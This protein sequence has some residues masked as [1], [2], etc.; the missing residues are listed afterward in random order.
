MASLHVAAWVVASAVVL[1]VYASPIAGVADVLAG[2][3][4]QVADATAAGERAQRSFTFP[5]TRRIMRFPFGRGNTTM[6][7]LE[8]GRRVQDEVPVY[9]DYRALAYYYAD[10]YVG[11]PSQRFTVITDTGA[12]R[13]CR[14]HVDVLLCTAT[15]C[16]CRVVC[17]A[18]RIQV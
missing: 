18:A 7:N 9:G 5:L 15:V 16:G 10:V 2:S 6:P 4:A 13:G 3:F 8:R 14:M 12:L 11:T 1:S 17:V